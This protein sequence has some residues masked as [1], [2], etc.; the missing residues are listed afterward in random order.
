MKDSVRSSRQTTAVIIDSD[1]YSPHFHAL[2]NILIFTYH[3]DL[4]KT[5]SSELSPTEQGLLK[6]IQNT[7]TLH[8]TAEVRFLDDSDCFA[9]IA[10]VMGPE[11]KLLDMFEE[12]SFGPFK[13][14][15]C[16][17][18]ALY[19]TGGLY[20]DT[21]LNARMPLWNVIP[22][23][24]DFVTIKSSG[25]GEL[26]GFFQ[27][28]VGSVPSHPI[29]IKYLNL[30]EQF[31]NNELQ[32]RG[33]LGVI[34]LYRAYNLLTDRERVRGVLWKEELYDSQRFPDVSPPAG[35][36]SNCRYIV[37]VP[38]TKA[39]PFYSRIVGSRACKH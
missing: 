6:N 12:E 10:N 22:P 9:S 25:V 2:P 19:E 26:T 3:K 32:V 35:V 39:V 14:D 28:F 27:A 11:S 38:R 8:P 16:R 36:S 30:F 33:P 20:F 13:A 37:S 34:F 31:H 5:P 4:L 24:A 17:G 15:I 21:D 7:I 1:S 29:W 18:A 23:A